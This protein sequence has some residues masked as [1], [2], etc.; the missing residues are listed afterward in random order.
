MAFSHDT[1]ASGT[2]ALPGGAALAIIA[3]VAA[4]GVIGDGLRMPWHLPADLAHFRKLT[5]GHAIIMGRRTWQSLGRALPN[6]QNIVV[7]GQS[8]Y[9]AQG[10][11]VANSL[12]QAIAC[13][14]LPA[15]VFVI[16]GAR[17]FAE[18]LAGATTLH[19]TEIHADYPGDV[20]FPP[21]D[22]TQWRESAREEHA[23]ADGAPAHAFVTL[24][25]K[26]S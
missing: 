25:R 4:N 16:G 10:G 19:L 11:Q 1:S 20:R 15:P 2:P 14:A 24:V 21:L 12:A 3:A 22:R 5:T 6:R 23:A 13:A 18:A 7:S 26:R 17:L 8:G 9:R